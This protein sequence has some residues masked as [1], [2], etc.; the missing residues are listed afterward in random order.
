MKRYT[1]GCR[2]HAPEV[3]SAAAPKGAEDDEQ[4]LEA[5]VASDRDEAAHC[6][7]H[8]KRNCIYYG[9]TFANHGGDVARFC[10]G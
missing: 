5:I 8:R 4:L 7:S 9:S 3:E 2:H 6:H 10:P 1:K